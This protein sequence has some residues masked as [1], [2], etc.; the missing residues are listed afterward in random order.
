MLQDEY[1]TCNYNASGRTL[2]AVMLQGD[3]ILYDACASGRMLLYIYNASGRIL[4]EC[5]ARNASARILHNASVFT[6]RT[7][8]LYV[9][10]QDEHFIILRDECFVMLQ[11]EYLVI[12]QDEYFILLIIYITLQDECFVM[13]RVEYFIIILQDECFICNTSAR[14]FVNASGRTLNLYIMAG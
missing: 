3:R 8:T 11:A 12:L 2:C 13:L 4:I 1:S 6:G 5:F 9:M 7:N 10:L 14:I